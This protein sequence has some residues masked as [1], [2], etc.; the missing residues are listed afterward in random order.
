M[1][2]SAKFTEYL[3]SA[4]TFDFAVMLRSWLGSVVGAS[5]VGASVVGSVLPAVTRVLL[6]IGVVN[7]STVL[8]I[9]TSSSVDSSSSFVV[10][11]RFAIC[12]TSRSRSTFVSPEP[13]TSNV[14]VTNSTSLPSAVWSL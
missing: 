2:S 6:A 9:T 13:I 11:S 3:A 8:P 4:A 10:G 12:I 5:V 14:T 1:L 7:G